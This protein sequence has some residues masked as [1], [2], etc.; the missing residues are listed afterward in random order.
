MVMIVFNL[1]MWWTHAQY[2]YIYLLNVIKPIPTFQVHCISKWRLL[3]GHCI[4]SI[5]FI[6]LC[7]TSVPPVFVMIGIVICRSVLIQAFME[8]TMGYWYSTKFGYHGK[9][10]LASEF[11]DFTEV[12]VIYQSYTTGVFGFSNHL[13]LCVCVC[14]TVPVCERECVCEC[15]CVCN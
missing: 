3:F 14:V 9:T 2:A 11:E 6:H 1:K 7:Y 10:F 4:G 8:L 15:V 5:D 12:C 13:C